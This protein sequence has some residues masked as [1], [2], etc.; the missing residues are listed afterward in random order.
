MSHGDSIVSL[1]D[2][3]SQIGSTSHCPYAAAENSVDKRYGLQFHPE[4]AHTEQGQ[5]ILTHFAE[6]I[7]HCPTTWN[8]ERFLQDIEIDIKKQVGE[9]NVFFISE[10]WH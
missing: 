5:Q 8:T 10:R 2:G 7:C 3:F 6:S 9:R 1:P 4:V